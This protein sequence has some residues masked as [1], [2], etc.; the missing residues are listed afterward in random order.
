MQEIAEQNNPY[1]KN[2]QSIKDIIIK[3]IPSFLEFCL[4][5]FKKCDN[6]ITV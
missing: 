6:I 4:T 5:N 1:T 3:K 2:N